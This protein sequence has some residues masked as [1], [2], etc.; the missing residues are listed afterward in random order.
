MNVTFA[1]NAQNG[2]ATQRGGRG[3][4][5][6]Q[7]QSNPP[8][9]GQPPKSQGVYHQY[10]DSLLSGPTRLPTTARLIKFEFDI[11]DADFKRLSKPATTP[12]GTVLWNI[13]EGCRRV[14]FRVCTR[15]VSESEHDPA[16]PEDKW[17]CAPTV[18]PTT[19]TVKVNE[20][21]FVDIP[22][23]RRAGGGTPCDIGAHLRPGRNVVSV[24]VISAAPPGTEFYG[25]VD[26]L[27]TET[28][29]SIMENVVKKRTLSET[30]TIKL[31]NSRV[32]VNDDD[33]IQ[34]MDPEIYVSVTDPLSGGLAGLPC[35]GD[36]CS[37]LD[38]FDLHALLESRRPK[39]CPH[40][41]LRT[42]CSSCIAS[43][44]TWPDVPSAD[45]WACPICGGDARPNHL[46]VDKF[47]Q[48]IVKELAAGAKE[49]GV[50]AKAV[51]IDGNGRWRAKPL[52]KAK[53][54]EREVVMIDD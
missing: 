48:G 46:V 17:V 18:W 41:G 54:E 34:V 15:P 38:I 53:E 37:H 6:A 2:A 35:R 31:I 22:Q 39:R 52:G 32:A 24:A 8:P 7:N 40:G 28:Q 43:P 16:F 1:P 33:D 26:I 11:T 13:F 25:A 12:D 36:T 50:C 51:F 3:P 42:A 19:L 45:T 47:L 9:S 5:P 10:I 30:G 49:E 21:G 23:K 29:S 27:D 44:Q 14:R 20:D 4:A